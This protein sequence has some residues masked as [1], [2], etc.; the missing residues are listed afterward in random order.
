[1]AHHSLDSIASR[2]LLLRDFYGRRIDE[3]ISDFAYASQTAFAFYRFDHW[4]YLR[5][6]QREWQTNQEKLQ[7]WWIRPAAQFLEGILGTPLLLFDLEI[8]RNPDHCKQFDVV[9]RYVLGQPDA[10]S[11][12]SLRRFVTS[13]FHSALDSSQSTPSWLRDRIVSVQ[14]YSTTEEIWIVKTEP[15]GADVIN[16]D[17]PLSTASYSNTLWIIGETGQIIDYLQHGSFSDDSWLA[18]DLTNIFMPPNWNQLV[19]EQTRPLWDLMIWEGDEI[20]G[21]HNGISRTWERKLETTPEMLEMARRF[22]LT[23]AKKN[24]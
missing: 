1:M 2:V 7:S 6:R 17:A 5:Q 4:D 18:G 3:Y 22:I 15:L 10:C 12:P 16:F 21:F 20:E 11:N 23:N 13:R 8:A 14:P 24:E 9:T 19:K